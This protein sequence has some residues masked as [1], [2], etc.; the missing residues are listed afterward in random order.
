MS[1]LLPDHATPPGCIPFLYAPESRRSQRAEAWLWH[2]SDG[3]AMH[4]AGP[5]FAVH[6]KPLAEIAWQHFRLLLAEQHPTHP[7]LF[8]NQ[9]WD[10]TITTC[11]AANE[12][13]SILPTEP[14]RSHWRGPDRGVER[15]A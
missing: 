1:H 9:P 10:D 11:A 14:R 3:F 6:S 13:C 7:A 5:D 4:R 8:L 2:Y 15:G 12:A